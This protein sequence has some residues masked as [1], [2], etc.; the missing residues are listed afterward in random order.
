MRI[1][2][3]EI[4]DTIDGKPTRNSLGKLIH[5]TIEGI[6]NFWRWFGDSKVL[7]S[8]GRPLVVYHGTIAD[9]EY[10]DNSKTGS[11]D[12]GLWGRGHYFSSVSNNANSYALRQGDESQVILAYVSIK[13]PLVLKTGN[14]L[15]IRLPDGTNY[16]DFV[17]PNLDGTKI[18]NIAI[19]GNHD[20]VIQFRQNGMIGDIVAYNSNQIKSA[21]GNNGN[22]SVSSNKITERNKNANK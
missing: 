6:R 18:K 10:F 1:N 8:Q 7:D 5:P 12:R 19:S 2:E 20:G 14:D 9:F 4:P 3:I 11:N 16:K 15:I 22:F 13:N 17:G 21:I